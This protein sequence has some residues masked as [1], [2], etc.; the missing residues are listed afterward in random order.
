[1]KIKIDTDDNLP[2]TKTIKLH[3][4]AIV[5]RSVFKEDGKSYP[6]IYL[7]KCFYEL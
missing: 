2:L 7:N 6:Q 3:N 1:M 5:I 4:L